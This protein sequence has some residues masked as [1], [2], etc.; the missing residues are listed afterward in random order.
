MRKLLKFNPVTRFVKKGVKYMNLPYTTLNAYQIESST[1]LIY[2]S[3]V[4]ED[5][6]WYDILEWYTDNR[7][8]IRNLIALGDNFEKKIH[9]K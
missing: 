2:R 8:E 7:A 1:A 6:D 9:A 5:E 4:T 3:Q